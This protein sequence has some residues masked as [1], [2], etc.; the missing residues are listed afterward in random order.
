M[1]PGSFKV[2]QSDCRPWGGRFLIQTLK[3]WGNVSSISLALVFLASG[4]NH[5]N[6]ETD[7][8]AK[9]NSYK[10]TRSEVDK[11]Y[12]RQTAGAPQKPLLEQERAMRLQILQQMINLQLYLQKAE[13]LGVL[14]TDE[15]VES[16]VSQDKAPYTK[17]EFAKKLQEMG[18]TEDE[19]RQDIRRK[20]TI[21]K[22]LNKEIG[23]KVTIS[24]VDIQNFYNQNKAQFNVIEP[25]YLLAHIYVSAL[26]NVPSSQIPGKAES[27][28]QAF[29]KIRMVHN[30][31]DSGEDFA[32]LA[33]RYS[34]DVDTGRNGGELQP[35]P[36]SSL[37]ERDAPTREAILKLKPN[38]YSDII[39]IVNPATQK[40]LGYRIV[41][42]L[43][44]EPAGQR[45]LN[46][47]NVQQFIRT[48]LRNQREQ[49]LRQ[50]YDEVVRDGAEIH[51]YYAEQI[52]KDAGQ[53]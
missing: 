4:C 45:G 37:K 44:K 52:V 21:D 35:L 14:A 9:V 23:S 28:T 41:K 32:V 22:L 15:E 34:E 3:R 43:G 5:Q 47:P 53:K 18:Y 33:Q 26:A 24:D 40:V 29:E 17:E 19:Y 31:L 50:A 30:R 1:T 16:R 12:Q 10:V 2:S 20:L 8:L 38:Q 49:L 7:V 36:E 27:E 39:K 6:S 51:N 48:Q 42:L 11:A 13:K 25:Q 46:D